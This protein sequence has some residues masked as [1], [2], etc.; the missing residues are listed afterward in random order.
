MEIATAEK[1]STILRRRYTAPP[2]FGATA[3]YVIAEK[4]P[5]PPQNPGNKKY[6]NE[7]IP[8]RSMRTKICAANA[9]AI[10]FATRF[11]WAVLGRRT[12]RK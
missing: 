7:V 4:V 9:E 3:S 5:R 11:P 12:P 6:L 2:W 1:L 10:M 8:R